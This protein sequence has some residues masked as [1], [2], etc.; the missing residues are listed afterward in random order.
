MNKSELLNRA[1][2]IGEW[3]LRNQI[4]NPLDANCGRGVNVY[5]ARTEYCYLT[6]NWTTGLMCACLCALYKRTGEAR[7]LDAAERAGRYIMSLQMLDSRKKEYYGLYREITPQSI[8]CAPRDA[9]SAAWGLV[10]LYNMTGK[11]EYLDSAKMFAEWHMEYAMI[12]GW[13]KYALYMHKDMPH[14][15][16]RGSFQSGTGLFYYDL[17][18]ATGDARFI[19]R[20]FRPIASIYRDQFIDESGQLILEREA[21]SGKI[22][23]LSDEAKMHA[24]NDD[25]GA[26]MLQAASDFFKDESFRETALR[27]ACWL[28][29]HQD[30]DGGFADGKVPS[31]VPV[32]LI[33]F[34]DLGTYYD[35]EKLLN[36]REKSL[37]KLY[38]MQHLNTG[39][40]KLDGAI[41]GS[42]EIIGEWPEIPGAPH[43]HVNI[44]CTNYALMALLK[45]ESELEGVWLGR[46]NRKWTDPLHDTDFDEY[47][48]KLGYLTWQEAK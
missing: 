48:K 17:F 7:W 43:Q 26:A 19:E 5:D 27:H 45:M 15:F 1:I 9:V 16:A 47:L 46:H 24:Y 30:A 14:F 37:D 25:F 4:K 12:E 42:R 10:W 34:H 23:E 36:A 35:N 41:Q 20:G 6:A 8:E 32:S 29:E 38:V 11:K 18:V 33:Y 28:A 2:L 40:P 22:V 3:M 39:N 44:R 31:G 13:P 21:F